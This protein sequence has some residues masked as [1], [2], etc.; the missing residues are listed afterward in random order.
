MTA[1]EYLKN[2]QVLVQEKSPVLQSIQRLAE[3]VMLKEPSVD[4]LF[5]TKVS[6]KHTGVPASQFQF[7]EPLNDL[8]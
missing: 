7:V 8:Q 4:N 2:I 5:C 6:P 3:Q 1:I